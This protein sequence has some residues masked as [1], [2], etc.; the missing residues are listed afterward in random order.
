MERLTL[1]I[2]GMSCDHCV[3]RVRQALSKVNGVDVESV[4]VGSAELGY[5]PGRVSPAQILEAVD[6]VGYTSHVGGSG[7]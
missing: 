5:D 1:Q 6:R 3:S 7:V 2:E 4:E